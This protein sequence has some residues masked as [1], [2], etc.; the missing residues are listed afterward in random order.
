MIGN[1]NRLNLKPLKYKIIKRGKL[2]IGIISNPAANNSAITSTKITA[3][4]LGKI[5][6]RLKNV[7]QCTLVVCLS[8]GNTNLNNNTPLKYDIDLA[9][10]TSNIDVII[11]GNN[12][13]TNP[14]NYVCH[15]AAKEEVMIHASS[16]AGSS[17]GRIDIELCS[18][19]QK[20]NVKVYYND[21]LA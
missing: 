11:S 20:R 19:M 15:N 1:D 2:K 6:D 13:V 7:H 12:E 3:N 21:G 8:T 18:K 16:F 4:A 17:V 9:S 14:I 10:L 5:A